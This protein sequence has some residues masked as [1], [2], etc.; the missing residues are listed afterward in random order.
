ME[1][2]LIDTDIGQDIDDAY[3]V[4]FALLHP[5]LHVEGITT[6]GPFGSLRASIV[7][8]LVEK[9]GAPEIPVAIGAEG[10]PTF[11]NQG[12]WIPGQLQWAGAHLSVAKA[13]RGAAVDLI[14]QV[15]ESHPGEVTLV[16]LG[17]LTNISEAFRLYPEIAPKVRRLAIM[18]GELRSLRREHNFAT[19]YLAA[20][21]VL[22]VPVERFLA[23]WSVSGRVRLS[24][25]A[26]ELLRQSQQPVCTVLT[27][28]TQAW[29]WPYD[30]VLFDLSPLLWLVEPSLFETKQMDVRVETTGLFTRGMSVAMGDFEHGLEVEPCSVQGVDISAGPH[31]SLVT[32]DIDESRS[33]SL[34][35]DVLARPNS[36]ADSVA[37][38]L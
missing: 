1:R 11:E 15:I 26:F 4:A 27:E 3:A 13:A 32:T 25:P 18:G 10:S 16:C 34:I 12:R 31:F 30:P 9:E 35:M 36:V 38:G 20:D 29:G 8:A 28:L 14:R 7:E 33:L 22:R 37:A 21:H 17:Q 6:V 24:R 5:H 2:I 19:D 23:T